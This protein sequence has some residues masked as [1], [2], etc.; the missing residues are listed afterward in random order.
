M[1]QLKSYSSPSIIPPPSLSAFLS[2]RLV[3]V[4]LTVIVLCGMYLFQGADGNIAFIQAFRLPTL[5][6]LMFIAVAIGVS[7]L[8]FQTLSSNQILTPSLMGFDALY[9]LL[10]TSIVFFFSALDYISLPPEMKFLSELVL[11]VLLSVV[12]FSTLLIK[13]QSD[14]SRM[15]L[16]G[17]IFGIL[18]RSL[19]GFMSRIMTPNDYAIVQAASFAQF[20]N[21]N[22]T[23]LP[24]AV[25]IIISCVILS[26]SIHRKLDV[27]TLGRDLAI[28]LGVNH[29]KCAFQVLTLIAIMVATATALV[30]PVVFLGLLITSIVYRISPTQRHASLLPMSALI[31][32]IVVVG[33]QLLLERLLQVQ[34][35]ISIVIEL[36]GGLVFLYLILK[37]RNG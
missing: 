18:F 16:T 36:M 17:I 37:R 33:G 29:K 26:Y 22:E 2:N 7:T 9:I 31:G 12:L 30:G 35:T 1:E 25:G 11:M 24:Y 6:G 23:L 19:S 8:L 32:I 21:I 13:L 3:L 28:N 10:Q 14:F 34:V 4:T 20:N 15:I 5:I 27:M